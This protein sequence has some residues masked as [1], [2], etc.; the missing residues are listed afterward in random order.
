MEK[1]VPAGSRPV[2]GYLE[3]GSFFLKQ[4]TDPDFAGSSFGSI[5]GKIEKPKVK[6]NKDGFK[7][8][9]LKKIKNP[10]V[11]ISMRRPDIDSPWMSHCPLRKIERGVDRF[12]AAPTP[13]PNR[14]TRP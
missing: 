3:T 11:G 1:A 4:V 5:P 8:F 9:I 10:A 12:P 13:F 14:S 7:V 6:R 2:K